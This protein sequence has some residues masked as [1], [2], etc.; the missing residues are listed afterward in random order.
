MTTT[1]TEDRLPGVA[2]P[3]EERVIASPTWISRTISTAVPPLVAGIVGLLVWQLLA[4]RPGTSLT[5]PVE[6]FRTLVALTFNGDLATNVGRTL[7]LMLVGFTGSAVSGVLIGLLLGSNS[8][9]DRGLSPYLVGLQS[10]PSA[11]WIPL[12]VLVGGTNVSSVIA[13]T[14]LGAIPSIAIGTRDAV[15][16]IPP[17]IVRAARTLGARGPI[18]M[19]QVIIPASLPGIVDG[20]QHGWAFAFRSLIAAE[21][22]LGTGIGAFLGAAKQENRVDK[23]LSVVIAILIVGLVVDRLG[24]ARARRALRRRRGITISGDL[25]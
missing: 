3:L 18:M 11:V 21:L 7:L 6:T 10:L 2:D 9:L 20:L 23:V 14:V 24:F 4:S 8:L 22:I 17:L 19:R 12:A 15:H 25:L 13:V 1:R 16:G 5:G